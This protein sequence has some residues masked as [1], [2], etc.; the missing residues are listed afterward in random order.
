MLVN[1]KVEIPYAEIEAF[2]RENHIRSLAFFGSILRDDF[3]PDSDID[4]LVEFED[5]FIPGL[6][7]FRIE[8]ELSEIIGHKVDLNTAGF[9]SP[10]MLDDV[11]KNSRVIYVA[12]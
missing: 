4:V 8:M 3:T 9:L 6:S 2:C 5:D 11:I 10:Y 7:F 12:A 1:S